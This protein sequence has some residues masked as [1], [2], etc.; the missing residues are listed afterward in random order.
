MD[1]IRFNGRNERSLRKALHMQSLLVRCVSK[2]IV[3]VVQPKGLKEEL[4]GRLSRL[5]LVPIE[6]GD[7]LPQY[8]CKPSNS[9]AHRRTMLPDLLPAKMKRN[10]NTS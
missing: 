9:S 1:C 7:G 3:L 6:D 8:V 2:P 10:V 4:P 5:L